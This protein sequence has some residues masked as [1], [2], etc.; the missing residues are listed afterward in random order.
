MSYFSICFLLLLPHEL[1]PKIR[2]AK[3]KPN[4]IDKA[5]IYTWLAW[6]DKP[7]QQIGIAVKKKT[8]FDPTHPNA[9]KFVTWFKDLYEL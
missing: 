4:H 2:G 8:I 5:N 3:I 6:Q 9:Q 7:E 1:L